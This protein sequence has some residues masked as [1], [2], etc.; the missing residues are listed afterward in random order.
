M[1]GRNREAIEDAAQA[2][3]LNSE[4]YTARE[5]LALA[6][7]ADGQFELALAHFHRV[8]RLEV[9]I[10]KRKLIL[11]SKTVSMQRL[12]ILELYSLQKIKVDKKIEMINDSS[13]KYE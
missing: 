5:A 7:Y 4:S 13:K 11:V 10:L 3:D 9:F 2:V 12:H 8:F 1:L 6:L